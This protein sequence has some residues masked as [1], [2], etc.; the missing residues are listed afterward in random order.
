MNHIFP[1]IISLIFVIIGII[2]ISRP[3]Q[4]ANYVAA[5]ARARAKVDKGIPVLG[6]I[7][8]MNQ[9]FYESKWGLLWIRIFS[10]IWTLISLSL[11][12]SNFLYLFEV[13]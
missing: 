9:S 6:G 13:L 1:I 2:F 12:V 3:K 7:S 8:K 5:H 10:I 4:L 11:V